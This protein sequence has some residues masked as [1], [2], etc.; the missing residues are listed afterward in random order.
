MV[1][2]IGAHARE[3]I[4]TL[5]VCLVGGYFAHA[6]ASEPDER[7]KVGVVRVEKQPPPL[8]M[9]TPIEPREEP[10]RATEPPRS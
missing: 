6:C 7:Q 8:P 2:V 4:P 5:A 3:A 1:G 10:E 9:V